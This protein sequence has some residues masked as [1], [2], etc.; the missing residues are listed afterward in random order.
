[1]VSFANPFGIS[2]KIDVLGYLQNGKGRVLVF[3]NKLKNF[4]LKVG[5]MDIL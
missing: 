4:P 2:S 5:Q 1:V 3:L